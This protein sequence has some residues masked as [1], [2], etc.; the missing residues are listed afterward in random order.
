MS[1][2]VAGSGN[3][4]VQVCGD[5]NSVTVCQRPGVHLWR[6]PRGRKPSHEREV[7]LSH[8]EAI[9]FAARETDLKLIGEWL[10]SDRQTSAL[11]IVGAGGTGKTR[12][13]LELFHRYEADWSCGFITGFRDPSALAA[14]TP[15]MD[16]N[17][18]LL[19]VVD[20]A[21]SHAED[22][23]KFLEDL[24]QYG[25][26]IPKVRILLL[27]RFADPQSGWYQ[28]L[29]NYSQTAPTADLFFQ[30]EPHLLTPLTS[31]LD[32]RSIFN[33]TLD[34]SAVFHPNS[35]RPQDAFDL[36]LLDKPHLA[37]P[38][39]LM[40]AALAAWETGVYGV[41]SL[42]RPDLAVRMAR[43]ERTRLAKRSNSILLPHLAAHSTL[44]GGFNKAALRTAARE[45]CES[46]ETTYPDGPGAL[47]RD[48]AD[49]LPGPTP[50]SSG[51]ILPDIIGEAFVLDV[52]PEGIDRAAHRDADAV[53]RTL[54][55]TLQD[56]YDPHEVRGKN[57]SGVDGS[58][59]VQWLRQ[60]ASQAHAGDVELLFGIANNLPESSVELAPLAAEVHSRLLDILSSVPGLAESRRAQQAALLNNY[61]NRLGALGD[62]KAAKEATGESVA[63]RRKLAIAR[64]DLYL[65]D[66]AGSLTNYGNRLRDLG[67]REAAKEAAGEAVVIYR[68]LAEA[69]P[70]A[71]LPNLAKVLNNYG[72]MLSDLGEQEVAKE[73]AGEALVI[74]RK[75]A[76]ARPEAFLP[77]LARSLNNYGNR[78]SDLGQR[79]AAKEAASEAVVIR[80]KLAAARPDA[81]LPNLATSLNNY[82]GMLAACGEREAAK[83]AAGEAVAIYRKLAAARPDAF[84]HGLAASLAAFAMV[85]D[86]PRESGA[87]F[88]EALRTLVP[89]FLRLPKAHA[90]LIGRIVADYIEVCE[91]LGSPLDVDLL[92]LILPV[93]A[94]LQNNNSQG[95]TEG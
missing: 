34:A 48:L 20:Y 84:V 44:S 23:R 88:H 69:R 74:R 5:A 67:E 89:I 90:H 31:D 77:D 13:A 54:T 39:V 28:R 40:M 81:F 16:R 29:F 32:R 72:N 26:R 49:M 12:L 36:G 79:E 37:D 75:L 93:L 85:T 7:L 50:E 19:A 8:F 30:P 86:D 47:A 83:E 2:T 80:R 55:R 18:P 51:V 41:L 58:T 27:E 3:I 59:S 14:S 76:E 46:L 17:R 64:P 78:L 38:L 33:H 35:T 94:Q 1:P 82:G 70:D 95:N 6:P 63:I 57:Q 10:S 91:D 87:L 25:T 15:A 61:G 45:E 22:L 66:L 60:L 24:A 65:A 92:M 68:K 52:K 43:R 42:S 53:I 71:F 9:P 62:R 73:A 11:C 56:F 4:L 21:A